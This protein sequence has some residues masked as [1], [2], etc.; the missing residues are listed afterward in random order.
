M[1]AV[2]HNKPK[3]TFMIIE[4]FGKKEEI[5]YKSSNIDNIVSV[6]RTKYD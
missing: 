4:R 1:I 2:E 6:L 5:I 3:N